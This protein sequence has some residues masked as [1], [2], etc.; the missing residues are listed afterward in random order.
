MGRHYVARR[1]FLFVPTLLGAS[2]LI[3]VLLRLVPA[4]FAV[5]ATVALSGSGPHGAVVTTVALA[6]TD[7]DRS[8]GQLLVAMP[9]MPDPRFKHTVIYMI[10]HDGTGALGLVVNRP[11]AT[12]PLG[13]LLDQPGLESQGAPGD[14]RVHWGG[15]VGAARAFALHTSD[16]V[17]KG[18]VGVDGSV[19]V[20]EDPEILRAI[21]AGAGPRRTLFILGYAG[22]GPGQLE[23]EI[24]G[25]A[26][27]V[28]PADEALV[29]GDDYDEKWEK[30]MARRVIRL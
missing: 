18:T 26:W 9:Q 1:L 24:A 2:V 17:G 14:I 7:A 28:V 16:Y 6:R 22:W 15:P 29:F 11:I 3:F 19:A 25:G 4:M 23:A 8:T 10:R 12:V 30:A 27:A 21:A 13:R 20:T 5:L